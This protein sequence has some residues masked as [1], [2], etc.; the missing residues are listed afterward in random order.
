[1][2]AAKLPSQQR[3]RMGTKRGSDRGIVGTHV[4]CHRWQRQCDS[5]LGH[6]PTRKQRQLRFHPCDRPARPMPM[7]G[8]P[9]QSAGI[10]EDFARPS[11]QLRARTKVADIVVRAQTAESF[12]ASPVGLSQAAHHAQ[13][14]T[15]TKSG[16][17][18]RLK[19][20]I[21]VAV[22]YIHGENLD[23]M[24]ASILEDLIGAVETHR[25]TID[26]CTSVGSRLMAL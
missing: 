23:A 25:P 22:T 18:C 13:P 7:T 24:A 1:A 4:L 10:R 2:A 17:P 15:N 9:A 14:Q 21:P 5:R 16:I 19:R 26:Q 8:Q 6:W 11:I 3:E 12:D 20:A